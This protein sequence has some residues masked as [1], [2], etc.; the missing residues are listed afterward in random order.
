MASQDPHRDWHKV[1]ID[2]VR[3]SI[4]TVV[5]VIVGILAYFGYQRLEAKKLVEQATLEIELAR[6]LYEALRDDD[7]I[8]AF[9]EQFTV[10][11]GSL[12]DAE[13]FMRRQA[14]APALSE[15]QRSRRLLQGIDDVLNNR[16][17]EGQAQVVAVQGR[18]EFRRGTGGA[19]IAARNRQVLHAGDYVKTSE[20]GSAEV[21]FFDGTFFTINP[22]SVILVKRRSLGGFTSRQ[23]IAL[24]Y[25]GVN[26]NT[27]QLASTV[28]TPEAE[29]AVETES[30]ARVAYDQ[31]SGTARFAALEGELVVSAPDGEERRVGLSSR[32]S[33]GRP[34]DPPGRSCRPPS[35]SLRSPTTPS[36]SQPWS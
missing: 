5:L 16:D 35:S 2:T 11:E 29:T 6:G 34:L 7:G 18:V 13:N 10:A 19:W 20:E 27:T 28:T 4:G 15:A 32:S 14:F 33:K 12:R 26:L 9:T 3:A 21:L 22:N 31:D 30:V 24:E 1:S 36:R 8:E 25:G 17:G 23:T